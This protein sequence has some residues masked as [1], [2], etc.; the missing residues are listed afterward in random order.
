[1]Q[2]KDD[3]PEAPVTAGRWSMAE[4]LA[5]EPETHLVV[6][7]D[8]EWI[9]FSSDRDSKRPLRNFVTLHSTEIYVMRA[10]G[11]DVR[12]LT[13]EEAFAGSPAWS[14]D[15]KTIYAYTAT[16]Q[17]VSDITGVRRVEGATQLI[18]IDVSS[19]AK[20]TFTPA[21]PAGSRTS[22]SITSVDR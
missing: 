15:G 21:S 4:A 9:A 2:V 17:D 20:R 3:V 5:G 7:P 6:S 12:R 10:D 13:N 18:A 11:S 8:G 1:M 14:P 22:A 16:L 19:G